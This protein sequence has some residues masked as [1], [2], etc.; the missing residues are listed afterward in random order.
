[1]R[2]TRR[3]KEVRI[4]VAPIYNQYRITITYSTKISVISP[5]PRVVCN[6]LLLFTS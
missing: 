3:E 4:D 2:K 5:R 1:M 6:K